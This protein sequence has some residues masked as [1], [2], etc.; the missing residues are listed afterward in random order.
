[1]KTYFPAYFLRAASMRALA[2]QGVQ[3]EL[4]EATLVG[5]AY[6]EAVFAATC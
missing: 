4:A 3:L 1:M 5:F 2:A 6:L